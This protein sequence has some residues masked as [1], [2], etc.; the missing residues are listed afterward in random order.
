MMHFRP[1]TIDRCS[2]FRD[3]VVKSVVSSVVCRERGSVLPVGDVQR[4]L[5]VAA[6]PRDPD[7]VSAVRPDAVRSVHARG[8]R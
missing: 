8:P 4:V 6:R 5:H 7:D 3:C 2:S 1:V